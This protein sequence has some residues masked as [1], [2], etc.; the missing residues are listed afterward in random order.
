MGETGHASVP[1]A[2]RCPDGAVLLLHVPVDGRDDHPAGG[3]G[4][5]VCVDA[6][7]YH[8]PAGGLQACGRRPARA[9]Q[10][11][12]ERLSQA[13]ALAAADLGR[14][15]LR[16]AAAGSRHP[17]RAGRGHAEQDHRSASEAGRARTSG[18][19]RWRRV[20]GVGLL[21]AELDTDLPGGTARVFSKADRG[22]GAVFQRGVG[23]ARVQAVSGGD[24]HAAPAVLRG[25]PDRGA[26]LRR[27][28]GGGGGGLHPVPA[29]HRAGALHA[30][31][32]IPRTVPAAASSGAGGSR[33]GRYPGSSVLIAALKSVIPACAGMT[34]PRFAGGLP[35][36]PLQFGDAQVQH[37]HAGAAEVDLG[38]GV[39]AAAFDVDDH[40]FP[41]LGVLDRF[42]DAPA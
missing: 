8:C 1:Q 4:C 26:G 9:A 35:S 12:A 31:R 17:V 6:A 19:H 20:C 21:Y 27:L 28:A 29:D 34:E 11:A 23:S 42:A 3:P 14:I 2:A 33:Q 25:L 39:G 5:A 24:H 18:R 22:Q 30:V 37:F 40:P 7:V 41:E 16:D 15:E 38:A 36:Q 10:F 32:G 13:G